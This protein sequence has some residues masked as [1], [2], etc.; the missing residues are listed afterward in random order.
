MAIKAK[1][2]ENGFLR[3]F[4]SATKETLDVVAPVKHF[5]DFTEK[6]VDLTNSYTVAGVNSGTA[7]INVATGG[8]M[9]ITTGAADDDDVDFATDLIFKAANRC[10]MEVRMTANDILAAAF[11]VGFTDATGEAADL[12]PLTFAT[13]SLTS[14]ASNCAMF[15]YDTDATTDIIRAVA[16]KADTD[17]TIFT[18]PAPVAGTYNTYRVSIAADG[19]CSF[20]LDGV[21][22]G[23]QASGITTTTPLCAYIGV[24]NREGAVNT[25]DVDYIKIWQGR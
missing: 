20:Y 3:Y 21:L 24:I 18:G 14:T 4:D 10:E 12:I 11:C 2:N 19:S 16:V 23:T 17:G 7:A 9:R 5:D 15:F 6:T 25:W 13:T 1:Y 8:T 22:L